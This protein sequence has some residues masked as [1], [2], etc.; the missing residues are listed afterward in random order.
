MEDTS[1]NDGQASH[2]NQQN[3]T[4]FNLF[5]D[6]QTGK[7]STI[8]KYCTDPIR[9]SG[10][11][12]W[13]CRQYGREV[14]A[15]DVPVQDAEA[16]SIDLK[17]QSRWWS[18]YSFY[19]AVGVRHVN[20]V[21]RRMCPNAETLM[22]QQ[23]KF[24]DSHKTARGFR[25]I[26]L[27]VEHAEE[28]AELQHLLDRAPAFDDRGAC[29]PD[30]TGSRHSDKEVCEN[31]WCDDYDSG[32]RVKDYARWERKKKFLKWLPFMIDF[33]WRYGVA[34]K[35]FLFLQSND[36]VLSYK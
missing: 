24:I 6:N 25:V 5:L 14:I 2:S 32:C 35:G 12:V 8:H 28:I 31:F 9:M 13:L 11:C 16:L 36:F 21:P 7:P 26:A 18:R 22:L 33:Y 10:S 4:A 30:V 20:V 17:G 29:G 15:W 19:S 34:G 1:A 23:I 27:P 3:D